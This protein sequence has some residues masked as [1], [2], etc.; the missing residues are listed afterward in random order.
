MK[1]EL[2]IF[3]CDGTLVDSE[4][5][6]NTIIAELI[7]ESGIAITAEEAIEKFR[8]TRFA[9]IVNF[10]EEATGKPIDYNFELEF[11]KRSKTKFENELQPIP[12][13]IDFIEALP[14]PFCIA[15]NGPQIKMETTLPATGLDKYF[16]NKNTFSAYDIGH[17]KPS[18]ELFQ[19]SAL[20]MDC[21]IDKCLVI[22]D[23]ISG[24]M[25][26]VNANI[27]LQV[28]APEDPN[29]FTSQGMNVFSDFD[30]LRK[31]LGF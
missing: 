27:D 7:N 19:Y 22:E 3:D 12:G 2:I 28:Y 14:I 31:Q 20:A 29:Q 18:P 23:T 25:G 5:I 6:S 30:E 13:V 21:P 1:Y 8:G 4:G 26:A 9:K 11:R 15:S 24:A 16:N 17:W 10:M